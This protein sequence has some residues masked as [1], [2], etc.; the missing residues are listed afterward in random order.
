M[1]NWDLPTHI[2]CQNVFHSY[3]KLSHSMKY[4]FENRSSRNFSRQVLHVADQQCQ[5]MEETINVVI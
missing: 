4:T 2:H 3:S 1:T 5:S